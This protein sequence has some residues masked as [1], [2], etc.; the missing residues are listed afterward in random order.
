MVNAVDAADTTL[1]S[2]SVGMGIGGV[3]LLS[4]VIV[5]PVV[6]GLESAALGSLG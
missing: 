1:I 5:A 6:L 3:D 4:T 2:A